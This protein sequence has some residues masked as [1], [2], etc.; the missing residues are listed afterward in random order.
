M[1]RCGCHIPIVA[2]IAIC[3]AM[4]QLV[5]AAD[6]TASPRGDKPAQPALREEL[7]ARMKKDQDVRNRVLTWTMKNDLVFGSKEFLEKVDQTL[8][9]EMKTVDADNLQWFKSIVSELGWPVRSMVGKD[10]ASAAYLIVQHAVQDRPFQRQCLDL[11]RGAPKGEVDPQNIAYL[12]DRVRLA[13]GKKQLYGTQPVLKDGRWVVEN[14]EDPDNL[15]QRR[16]ELGLMPIEE[17]LKTI[18][19]VF[20]SNQ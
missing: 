5:S 18:A 15:D 17:Y 13:E 10:G 11:M 19:K 6:S 12:T 16:K 14:V 8:L 7:L 1:P 20:G 4:F 3:I 2:T 9:K